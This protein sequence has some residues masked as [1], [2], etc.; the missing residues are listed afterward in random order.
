MTSGRGPTFL[1][2]GPDQYNQDAPFAP[3]PDTILGLGGNDTITTSTLGGSLVYGDSLVGS[4]LSGNDVLVARGQGDTLF[5][6]P[7][8]DSLLG[9][10]PGVALVG[11]DGRDTIVAE[12]P[13][14]LYGGAGRDLLVAV[15]G[16]NLMFGNQ[17][18]DTILGGLQGNDTIYGGKGDDLI[19][20]YSASGQSN[21]G[22]VVPPA[23]GGANQGNNWVNG[24]IGN[25][26]IVGIN[27]GDSL[28][29]GQDNDSIVGVGSLSYLSGDEGNDTLRI[30]NPTGSISPFDPQT[31]LVGVTQVT[32]M[33][34]AGDDS[35]IGPIGRFG[36]GQNFLDGG[37]GNDTIMSFAA[38]DTLLGGE[39]DDFLSTN[40]SAQLTTQGINSSLSGFAGGSVLD[41]GPG[42]DTLV[43]VFASDSLFGGDGNDS[44]L[45]RRFS[46]MD[47]GDGNNTLNGG[48][49]LRTGTTPLEVSLFGGA[50][51]D[52]IIGAQGSI[53]NVIAGGAGDDTIVFGTTNDILLS[54]TANTLGN[55]SITAANVE[56]FNEGNVG[57]SITN[58]Q[59]NNTVEGSER[60]DLLVT[61]S[62][63]DLLLGGNGDDTLLGGAG[64]DFLFGGSGNDLL[65]GGPGDDTLEGGFGVNTLV[66]GEGDNQFFYRFSEAVKT[67]TSA[68]FI[69]DFNQGGNDRL[70]FVR[71]ASVGGFGFALVPGI[72]NSELGPNQFIY[73]PTGLYRD[74]DANINTPVLIYEQAS[75]VLR[76]DENGSQPEGVFPVAQF[77]QLPDGNFPRI[78]ASDILII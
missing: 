44:L 46:I 65:D 28:Y 42:N 50:G 71:D 74:A 57:V 2:S 30:Q 60:N 56:F 23:V 3:R 72:S 58:L 5:G 12:Q 13:A 77:G 52:L 45:G 41:G 63:N 47:G 24:N 67:T 59:G 7:G 25:D 40:T 17:D 53:T 37:A 1:T 8:N 61:G 54:D 19:G 34:G 29:G 62:G 64:N 32:M 11:G 10:A 35:I 18:E 75:G 49:W 73:L 15:S 66:G 16:G 55:D 22:L 4:D 68:D 43:S 21:V 27:T 51:N 9:R 38:E 33:G 69:T 6:G 76:Y 48:E 70:V 31:A 78:S 36:E 20:F 26:T 14:T 39:G